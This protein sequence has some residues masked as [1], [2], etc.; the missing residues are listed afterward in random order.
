MLPDQLARYRAAVADER[1]GSELTGLVAELRAAGCIV[2]AVVASG[3]SG[4]EL[5][6]VPRGYPKDHPR[7]A[8]LRHK[9]LMAARAWERPAWLHSVRA[10]TEV[11]VL[12]RAAAPLRDWL[13]RNVGVSERPDPRR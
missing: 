4:P 9:S 5:A 10:G 8:L 7:E 13:A 11:V 3:M 2:G 1:S 6:R 12:W